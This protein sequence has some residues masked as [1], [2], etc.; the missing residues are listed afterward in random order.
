MAEEIKCKYYSQN[1]TFL[2]SQ[3]ESI[4]GLKD[5]HYLFSNFAYIKVT[6]S[7]NWQ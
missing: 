2:W 6:N 5:W 4:V 7:Q 1:Y 3:L